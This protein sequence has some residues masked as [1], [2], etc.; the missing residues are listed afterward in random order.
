MRRR[1][2]ATLL[3]DH[4]LVMRK[5]TGWFW[6]KATKFDA[7]SSL[8]THKYNKKFA[9]LLFLGDSRR[10]STVGWLGK[11]AERNKREMRVVK[12]RIK[13]QLGFSLYIFCM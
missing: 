9:L 4:P 8:Q 10:W 11:D 5:A 7:L 6:S 2:A 12:A 3:E 13:V 1:Q